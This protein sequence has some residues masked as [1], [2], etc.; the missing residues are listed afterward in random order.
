MH[1]FSHVRMEALASPSR[2]V[3]SVAG[4]IYHRSHHYS[5]ECVS[6]HDLPPI[7]AMQ[8]SEATIPELAS[9]R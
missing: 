6:P 2:L 3:A 1:K 8:H 5:N 9:L 4:L 7:K